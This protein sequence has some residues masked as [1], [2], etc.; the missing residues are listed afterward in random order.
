MPNIG[1]LKALEIQEDSAG[2]EGFEFPL[3]NLAD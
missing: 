3:V 2:Q 1:P